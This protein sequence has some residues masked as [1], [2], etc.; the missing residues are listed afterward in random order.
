MA[1]NPF[2]GK[3]PANINNFIK[4]AQESIAKAQQ[5][6]ENLAATRVDG[7]AGGGLVKA[8]VTGKG[9]VIEI[10]IDKSVV[11]PNDVETLEDL[12]TVAVRDA[13]EKANALRGE[14]LRGV[15]PAGMESQL[16]SGLF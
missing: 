12:V 9:D 2:G 13:V 1:N 4:Q 11:D 8:A 14:S 3:M 16:P 7:Q 5:V 10:K 6:D 15:I